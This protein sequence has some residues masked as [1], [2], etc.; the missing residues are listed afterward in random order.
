[1][2]PKA[3]I[4]ILIVIAIIYFYLYSTDVS[5]EQGF[6]VSP[7]TRG[8]VQD[9]VN[10]LAAKTN[11]TANPAAP[12]GLSV[13]EAGSLRRMSMAALN[14]Y[15]Q[16]HTSSGGLTNVLPGNYEGFDTQ[17]II[18]PLD[19]ALSVPISDE[20]S[21]L[22]MEKYCR[23]YTITGNP[24]DDATFAANCGVC[25]S[26]GNF[27]DAANTPIVNTPAGTGVLL[28]RADKDRAYARKTANNYRYPRAMPSLGRAVCAGATTQDNDANLPTL[29]I[30]AAMYSEL[31]GQAACIFTQ[32]YATDKSCGKCL[33]D[34]TS[35]TYIKQPASE[36]MQ[37][38]NLILVGSG[39]VTVTSNGQPVVDADGKEIADV[40]LSTTTPLSV[41]LGNFLVNGTVR[42]Y[43]NEGEP[44]VVSVKPAGVTVPYVGGLIQSTVPNGST[45]IEE[46]YNTILTDDA[47]SGNVPKIGQ[48]KLGVSTFG[49][50]VKRIIPTTPMPSGAA[51]RLSCKMPMTF[52]SNNLSQYTCPDGP[53]INSL[54]DANALIK[55]ECTGQSPGG[56]SQ[57]CLG[58]II[59][60]AGCST[61]GTWYSSGL[62]AAATTGNNVGQIRNWITA[63]QVNRNQPAVSMGCYGINNSSP[64]DGASPGTPPTAECLKYLYDNTSENNPVQGR[65]YTTTN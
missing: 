3:I 12:I 55:D 31:K 21:M 38:T 60:E 20:T 65:A 42:G 61:G 34:P 63:Q 2:G 14:S 17:G 39:L 18:D 36:G 48:P 5:G 64:C 9:R 54:E 6:A 51:M 52:L 22:A 4:G 58:K 41:G 8:H 45:Y 19:T 44:F 33:T 25:M 35:W 49:L 24:F 57:N 62:P 50:Y 53:L 32:D 16:N 46:M 37:P 1:M 28:Y 56:Y 13:A 26:T 27:N 15:T 23:E 30:D 10:P 47:N 43:I 40:A 11:P 59:L 29:A 7:L